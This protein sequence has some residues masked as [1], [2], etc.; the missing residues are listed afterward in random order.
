MDF[1]NKKVL[2][3]YFSRAGKNYLSGRIISLRV[4]NTEQLAKIIASQTGGDLFKVER[5][6]AYDDDYYRCTEEAKKEQDEKARPALKEH[7]KDLSSYD[8]IFLGSPDW[9]SSLPMPLFTFIEE[10][11]RLEGKEVYPFITHEGSGMGHILNDLKKECP[12]AIIHDGL[13]IQGSYV[14]DS[15]TVVRDWLKSL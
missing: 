14:M 5:K 6:E 3:V 11:K 8:I 1:Q 7:M 13:A 9:W 4:G 15:A 12:K 2:V 10:N